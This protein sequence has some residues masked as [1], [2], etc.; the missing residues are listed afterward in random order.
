M[1]CTQGY[2]Y[3]VAVNT[4]NWVTYVALFLVLANSFYLYFARTRLNSGAAP[5]SGTC[6]HLDMLAHV[7]YA[8]GAVEVAIG[9]VLYTVLQPAC[10]EDCDCAR[11][12]ILNGF[13]GVDLGPFL[14]LIIGLIWI[15]RARGYQHVG[16]PQA[17][18]EVG[19]VDFAA[20][21]AHPAGALA[22]PAYAGYAPVDT[23]DKKDEIFADIIEELNVT[24]SSMGLVQHMEIDGRIQ[25]TS[26]LQGNPDLLVG[27]N[28]DL[29]IGKSVNSYG[30][31]TM[32]DCNFHEC[33]VNLDDFECDRVLKVRPPDGEFVAMNYHITKGVAP[34]FRIQPFMEEAGKEFGRRNLDLVIKIMCDLPKN[35]FA[36]DVVIKCP[37]P[38][39]AFGVSCELGQGV[40][41]QSAE[42]QAATKTVQWTI[43]RFESSAEQFLRCH[44]ALPSA[45]LNSPEKTREEMGPIAMNFEVLNFNA[46][47]LKIRFLKIAERAE[48]YSPL[49]WLRYITRSNSYVCPVSLP[50]N[51]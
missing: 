33:C 27:L 35:K 8:F 5:A 21:A 44:I 16:Q 26:L 37:M 15:L 45:A 34:P 46:S 9:I 20:A 4:Y 19:Y 1:A 32:D 25:M 3:N 17:Q 23:R 6:F 39:S 18:S 41:G 49:R 48:S 11:Y 14:I 38:K 42:Y 13:F 29:V 47:G 50:G 10:P 2:D 51:S 40:T 22:P 43:K 31:V 36:G 28:Q 7:Q 12:G 30:S 24:F